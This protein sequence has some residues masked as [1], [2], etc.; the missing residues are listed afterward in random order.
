VRVDAGQ[1][2]GVEFAVDVLVNDVA[3]QVMHGDLLV[4]DAPTVGALVKG[5]LIGA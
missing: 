5:S 3:L 2:L 1:R 4:V